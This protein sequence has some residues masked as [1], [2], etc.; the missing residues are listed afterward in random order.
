MFTRILEMKTAASVSV[1]ADRLGEMARS[2]A[3]VSLLEECTIACEM[4]AEEIDSDP[5]GMR[6]QDLLSEC[7]ASCGAYLGATV[8]ESRYTSRYALL[9]GEI[10]E[11]TARACSMRLELATRCCEVLCRACVNLVREDYAAAEAN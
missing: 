5:D 8:R 9:C 1:P 7:I 6:M 4:L 10:C 2:Y 3:T 11:E